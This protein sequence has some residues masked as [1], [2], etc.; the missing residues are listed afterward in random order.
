MLLRDLTLLLIM[1]LAN[2]EATTLNRR[3]RFAEFLKFWT[4][5]ESDSEYAQPE[6][7]VTNVA[8]YAP[9]DDKEVYEYHG[10]PSPLVANL[11]EWD[12]V[13]STLD[14]KSQKLA[15]LSTKLHLIL[16]YE[17]LQIFGECMLT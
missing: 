12:R 2:T 9:Y 14:D 13:V 10:R 11:V 17:L 1:L 8:P 15:H 5:K 16:K 4:G 7:I 3:K 6:K